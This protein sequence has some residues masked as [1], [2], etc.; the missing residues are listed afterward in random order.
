MRDALVNPIDLDMRAF[1][2][3]FAV[4]AVTWLLVS[5]PVVLRATRVS[6]VEGLRHG[7]QTMPVSA[8]SV[9]T[10]QWLMAGQVALTVLLLVGGLL[11][12]RSYAARISLPTGLDANRVATVV[13][14][15]VPDNPVNRADLEA[16]LMGRL[17]NADGVE[18]ISR[19]DMLPPSTQAGGSGP[20]L[21]DG[22]TSPVGR[23]MLSFYGVDPD[24]FRTLGVN[25]V[26][27]RAFDGT[28][29]AEEVVVD[30]AFARR[31]WPGND[32]IGARFRLGTMSF[33]GVREFRIVGISRELRADR[34][35]VSGSGE[36]V[37]VAYMRI[38]SK[39]HP[40]MF[41]VK[42][43]SLG[44]L[45]AITSLVRSGAGRAIV[46]VDTVEARYERLEGD[47][48]L[49]AA[50]TS[51]YG[52]L[53]LL[54]AITGVYSVMAFL[55]AGRTREIGIRMALGAARTDVRRMIFLSSLRFVAAGAVVGLG[56]AALASRYIASQLFGVTPT[57][58][59]TYAGVALLVMTTAVAATWWPARRASAIDPA[60]T[61]RTE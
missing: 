25:V 10:R 36:E 30:E 43:D 24:Y 42:L 54:V 40:L 37:F 19:T 50:V 1:G 61:L 45:P 21:I 14:S 49:S 3:M 9:T 8:T 55:V 46:R 51:G 28:A 57:D 16:S 27:G 59:P 7:S 6:V 34:R 20:L 22:A 53:G 38:A 2:L 32:A 60:I 26:S 17:R 35:V 5:L 23:P 15:P 31:F 11:Y 18:S 33:D 12:L 44:R 47:R 13:V 58:V 4:G 29:A 39:S 48:W 41:V 52:G 56:A